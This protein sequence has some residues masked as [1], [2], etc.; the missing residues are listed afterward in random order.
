MAG[1]YDATAASPRHPSP[2]AR[3]AGV[4]RVTRRAA[5]PALQSRRV[6]PPRD[7][8]PS[9]DRPQRPGAQ[10][11]L[12]PA[13]ARAPGFNR[14]SRSDALASEIESASAEMTDFAIPTGYGIGASVDV[15]FPRREH[16]AGAGLP[17]RRARARRRGTRSSRPTAALR[18]GLLRRVRLDPGGHEIE[19][20]STARTDR[21]CSHE[22]ARAPYAP[23]SGDEGQRSAPAPPERPTRRATDPAEAPLSRKGNERDD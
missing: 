18:R 2:V 20:V 5:P 6:Q 21:R 11:R 7:D 4:P 14:A 15:A 22:Y 16:R 3:R 19:V 17:R 10:P 13:G 12:P 23:R 1:V 9:E 8:R